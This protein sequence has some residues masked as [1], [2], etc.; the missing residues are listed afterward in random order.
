MTHRIG[1][2]CFQTD[3]A[4]SRHHRG[5]GRPHRKYIVLEA[6]KQLASLSF[7]FEDLFFWV[8]KMKGVFPPMIDQAKGK[9]GLLCINLLLDDPTGQSDP[10]DLVA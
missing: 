7:Q 5:G 4:L 8:E 10:G 3:W 6:C 1:K 9:K 2:L